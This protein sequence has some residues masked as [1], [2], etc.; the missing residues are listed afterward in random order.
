MVEKGMPG[1]RL[2]QKWAD[3][4]GMRAS[5][6]A[7]LVFDSVHVP[8]FHR[9]GAEGEGTLQMMRNLEV[10]RLTLAAMS[11]GIGRRALK[12]MIGYANERR[13]FGVP[14]APARSSAGTFP[15]AASFASPRSAAAARG[16]ASTGGAPK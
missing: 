15:R 13:A 8:A 14:R 4:L 2:G 11:V 7:E 6:T 3:K 10:E 1:F 12:T 9:L 5:F 16:P